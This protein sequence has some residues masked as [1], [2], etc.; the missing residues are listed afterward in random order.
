MNRTVLYTSTAR[1]ASNTVLVSLRQKFGGGSAFNNLRGCWG[2]DESLE[3]KEHGM[4]LN[5]ILY[6]NIVKL[7]IQ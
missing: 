3:S 2:L 4:G 6:E 7:Q 5:R 1:R